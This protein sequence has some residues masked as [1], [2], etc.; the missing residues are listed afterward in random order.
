MLKIPFMKDQLLVNSFKKDRLY[1][2][3]VGFLSFNVDA[4]KKMTSG[5]RCALLMSWA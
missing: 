1:Q 2:R 3:V 5:V 4:M